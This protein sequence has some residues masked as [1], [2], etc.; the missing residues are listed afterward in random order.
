[1]YETLAQE[2]KRGQGGWKTIKDCSKEFYGQR[3]FPKYTTLGQSD[4]L[5]ILTQ[6]QKL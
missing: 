2:A 4:L 3:A 1:M 5:G 6:T